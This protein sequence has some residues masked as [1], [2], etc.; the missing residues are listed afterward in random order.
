[1]GSRSVSFWS[2]SVGRA[3]DAWPTPR[4][5]Y[6]AREAGRISARLPRPRRSPILGAGIFLR[7][8]A[9]RDGLREPRRIPIEA[10]RAER[11]SNVAP[12]PACQGHAPTRLQE[13]PP[14]ALRRRPLLVLPRYGR[15]PVRP[16]Q[17]AC[18]PAVGPL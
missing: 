16:A 17:S 13:R 14:F 12:A 9:V 4:R 15:E 10:D 11:G 7:Q 2:R 6:R 5:R 3:L 1:M 8:P 18:R